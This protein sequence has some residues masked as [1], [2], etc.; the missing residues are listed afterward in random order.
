MT[1][2]KRDDYASLGITEYWRFYETGQYHGTKLAGDRLE[3]GVYVPLHVHELPGGIL[4]G[5][6]EVL[7]LNLRW[8]DGELHWHDPSTGERLPTFESERAAR[9]EAEAARRQAEE[10]VRQLEEQLRQSE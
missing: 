6:S 8:Q 9:L 7:G 10:R 2:A 1:T 3:N 5:Y 4:Q